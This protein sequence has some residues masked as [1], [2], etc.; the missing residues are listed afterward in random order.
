MISSLTLSEITSK[1]QILCSTG[2]FTRSSDPLSHEAIVLYGPQFD[3][4]GFEVIFYPRWYAQQEDVIQAL[5]SCGLPFPVL[6]VEKSVGEVFGSSDAEEREQGV[7][8]F[9]QNCIFAQQIGAQI[10]VLHLWG[11]PHGDRHLEHNLQPLSRCLDIAAQHGLE[12]AIE[13]IP[14]TYADPLTNV[15]RAVEHDPRSRVALDTEFLAFHGQLDAVFAASW[16]WQERLVRH[17]HMKDYASQLSAGEE[18]RY[19]HPGE[20]LIDFRRFVQQLRAAGYDGALSLEARAID[21]WRE[22]EDARI[23][24]SLQ[25]MRSLAG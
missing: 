23:Q 11:L 14:C 20:G 10:V 12:L 22:V 5:Q 4:D 19:L 1:M 15:R 16:L 7:L 24:R 17:V 6:H 25:F 18:R 8:R 3:V 9:E 13:T 21:H 2:V